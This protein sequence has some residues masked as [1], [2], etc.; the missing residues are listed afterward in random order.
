MAIPRPYWVFGADAANHGT[1]NRY[2]TWVPLFLYGSGIK[3]GR[4]T[5][6]VSPADAAPTLAWL[7]GVTMPHPDGRPLVEALLPQTPR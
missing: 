4:Y 3:A 2:D 6:A 5:Q 7:C 1:P